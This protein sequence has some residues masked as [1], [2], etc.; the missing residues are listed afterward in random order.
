MRENLLVS[1]DMI[2]Q[3]DGIDTMREKPAEEVRCD[4]AAVAYVLAVRDHQVGGV[5]GTKIG[6]ALQQDV[7]TRHAVHITKECDGDRLIHVN[8]LFSGS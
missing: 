1:K 8:S 5:I 3:S 6:D 7:S 4:S 2:T